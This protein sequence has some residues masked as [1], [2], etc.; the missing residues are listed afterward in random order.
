MHHLLAQ[1]NPQ[2]QQAV[3][4]PPCHMM[5][6]AG[7]GSGKTRVLVHRIAWLFEQYGVSPHCILAVTF[8]NKAANEMRQRI[9]HL[10]GAPTQGLWIG[11]F[12]GI[13]HRLLRIHY[14]A[15]KLP[16]GFQVID[17]DDQ[18][19]LIRRVL[20]NLG[21]DE[22][23][24]SPKQA[25][26][27][28]NRQKDNGLRPHHLNAGGDFYQQTLIKI[29]HHYQT[30]CDQNGLVDF[31]ELLLRTD[32]LFQQ[33]PDLC[34]Q[35]QHRFAHILI[36]EFQDTNH[37]QYRFIKRLTNTDNYLT[38][39][40]D[41]D[42]SIYAWRGARVENIQRFTQE[43][44]DVL[45][46]RLEQ[47][48]RSTK[49]ILDAANAVI[50]HNQNRLGKSLWTE[51]Q[52]GESIRLYSAFNEL[53]EAR[54]IVAQIHNAKTQGL[55]LRD[56]AILYRSNAQSRV[57]EEALLQSGVPYRVYGG[58][59]FFE[60]AEIKNALAYCR[61]ATTPNDDSAF[62]RI[63]NTPT[64][65]IGERTIESI[66]Q[67]AREHGVSLWEAMQ[68]A[69]SH[70]RLSG[71]AHSHL[72]H[73]QALITSMQ[74]ALTDLPL[75]EQLEHIIKHSGLIEFYQREPGEKTQARIDNLN[76]LITA[77]GQF[78]T[79][80]T[81]A[82]TPMMAFL[83]HA[84][85]EA[86]EGQAAAYEDCVQLMT[87]HS[88]K[89][90]EFPM[91]VITGMEE[92]LFPPRQAMEDVSRLE[93][94]RRLCYVAM[95]RAMQHLLITYAQCRRLYGENR[96][97]FPSRFL[98]EIPSECISEV[99]MRQNISQPISIQGNT[100]K[101]FRSSASGLSVQGQQFFVGQQVSHPKFGDGII[102]N[103]EGQGEQARLQI[104]FGQ[105]GTKW[106]VASYARLET[107]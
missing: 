53:D 27:F 47:N 52:V 31:N 100:A 15:A 3:S 99:R 36:D 68:H 29:Y 76:E 18:Y 21:L 66:R 45:T 23:H 84:A 8:T 49:T 58:L 35:Y 94:E 55:R 4:A 79:S 81:Q 69:L 83:S 75:G 77:A 73:F 5:V 17:S 39:V 78:S 107:I 86:G 63:I 65:G 43:F 51:S 38:V 90:L 101:R 41:D 85:L 60:R 19:R 30:L 11:T 70:H 104:N 48:Y 20:K 89:G 1:L 7:A 28:I 13:A 61:L 16:E 96:Q 9:E 44:P 72:Q 50:N 91:V 59:R 14:D 71:R 22:K 97:H 64:R 2:Q 42:Q 24:W 10:F 82:Q 12:H 88:A 67:L 80:D 32:E 74:E 57:I 105:C 25:Q 103:F 87:M 106:L 40:G 54:F 6:L 102:L 56:I 33:N 46:I 92:E 34:Q 93:E 26:H 37:I 98:R 95:T 62:E